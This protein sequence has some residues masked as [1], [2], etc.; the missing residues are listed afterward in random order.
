M[1]AYL[2]RICENQYDMEEQL[3]LHGRRRARFRKQ[4]FIAVVANLRHVLVPLMQLMTE[5]MT[6]QIF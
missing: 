4:C 6:E 1:Y 5:L 2:H 3:K